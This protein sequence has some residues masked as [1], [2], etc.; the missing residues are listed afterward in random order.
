MQQLQNAS[1]CSR[2]ARAVLDAMI[3]VLISVRENAARRY[4]R[5]PE[6]GRRPSLIQVRALGILQKRPGATLS[7][8]ADQLSLTLS[9]TSRLVDGLVRKRLVARTIPQKNRRTLSLMLTVAGKKSLQTALRQ[10]ETELVPLIAKLPEANR[11]A[12][13]HAMSTLQAIMKPKP[14]AQ[15]SAGTGHAPHPR[16]APLRSRF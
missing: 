14:D 12:L 13:T 5:E 7:V 11:V 3:D 1:D 16:N 8:L 2:C 9:A 10:T 6:K 15:S 4:A